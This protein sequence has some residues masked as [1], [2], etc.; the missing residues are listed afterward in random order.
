MQSFATVSKIPKRLID[1]LVSRQRRIQM[2]RA[3]FYRRY[4]YNHPVSLFEVDR[5]VFISRELR[6][7]FNGIGKS[8]HSSVIANLVRAQF[9]ND[10]P[11]GQAKSSSFQ[12]PS[13]LSSEQVDALA[14][15]FKF[16]LVRNPYTRTLSAYLDKVVRGKVVPAGLQR[17]G[18]GKTPSF[19]DF[20]LYLED[21]G[22]H[23]AV[24]WAPQHKMLVLPIDQ[25]DHI[26]KLE[27]FDADFSIVLQRLGLAERF[28]VARHDPHKTNSDQ[29]RDSYY[30]ERSRDIVT[31][32]LADD[33]RLLGYC[34]EES[35]V[36][37][38]Q[39]SFEAAT[40]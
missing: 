2:I 21:G 22:L 13:T 12:R 8:G 1:R 29:R 26:A 38:G 37:V 36:G 18:G 31:R 34:P 30:C 28:E 25:F 39:P 24:H 14:G 7:V 5:R 4:P 40:R 16:T 3:P 23:D 20:C 15:F 17:R 10:I 35:D 6:L 9:G 19:L 32:L 11:I 33:F 27:S